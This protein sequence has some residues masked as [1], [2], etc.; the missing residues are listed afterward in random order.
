MNYTGLNKYLDHLQ[1]EFD[2]EDREAP[3]EWKVCGT[4][5]FPFFIT[6][7]R[8]QRKLERWLAKI[9]R[10]IEPQFLNWCAVFDYDRWS[11]GTAIHLLAG[12]SAVEFNPQWND[13]WKEMG[14]ADARFEGYRPGTFF[15]YV[16]QKAISGHHFKVSMEFCG[17]GLNEVE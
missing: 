17:W 13:S 8:A 9:R 3:Y 4:L 7:G 5:T 14:G 2:A 15:R 11:G 6:P 12:G 16:S 1:K 10:P